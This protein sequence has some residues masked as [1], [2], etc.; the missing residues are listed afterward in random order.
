MT[1][2]ITVAPAPATVIVWP[3]AVGSDHVEGLA[4]APSV[5]TPPTKLFTSVRLLAASVIGP[6]NV[7]PLLSL[8]AFATVRPNCIETGFDTTRLPPIG[9][10]ILFVA[11]FSLS[12]PCPNG[13]AVPPAFELVENL[14][15]EDPLN[16]VSPAYVFCAFSVALLLP[17]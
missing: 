9:S 12:V 4:A 1:S 3:P 17:L 11:L 7:S 13:P 15:I 16:N 14:T 8:A 10:K 6:L 2:L 5:R